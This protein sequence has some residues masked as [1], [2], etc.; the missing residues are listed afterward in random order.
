MTK[1]DAVKEAI[2]MRQYFPYRICGVIEN[3]DGTFRAEARK[4]LAAFNNAVRNG[5]IAYIV[6]G[7]AL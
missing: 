6:Q 5:R 4:T 1:D 7:A 2:R 3:E